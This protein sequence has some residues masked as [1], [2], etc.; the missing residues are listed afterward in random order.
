VDP[1]DPAESVLQRLDDL[2]VDV[3]G[4]P[5][6]EFLPEAYRVVTTEDPED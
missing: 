3:Q 6:R 4:T 5:I 2:T 1:P